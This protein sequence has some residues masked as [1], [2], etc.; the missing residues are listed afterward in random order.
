MLDTKNKSCLLLHSDWGIYL[1]KRFAEKFDFAEY[2]VSEGHK[3]ILLE[4]PENEFYW[5]TWGDVLREAEYHNK[6]G[7]WYLYQDGD[8]F[9][10]HEDFDVENWE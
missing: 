6:E 4:G 9:R 8:L 3:S 5:E 10:I 7:K 2:G 1:P